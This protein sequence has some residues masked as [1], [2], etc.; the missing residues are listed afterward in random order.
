M[1][2]KDYVDYC[3]LERAIKNAYSMYVKKKRRL[4]YYIP[5][6]RCAST[7]A[8]FFTTNHGGKKNI[9]EKHLSSGFY[10]WVVI[11]HLC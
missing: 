6:H 5:K 8:L 1:K 10:D 2:I 11:D 4:V 7:D 9:A 3:Y